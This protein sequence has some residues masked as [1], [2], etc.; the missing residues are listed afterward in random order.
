MPE[1]P[2]VET[3][4][5]GIAPHLIGQ[6]IIKPVVRH[7]RLRWPVPPELINI[8][9]GRVVTSVTRRSKYLLIDT[10]RGTLILH[11]GMSGSLRVLPSHTSPGKHDHF[12]L[13]LESGQCLRL[14]DP[15]RFGAVLWTTDPLETHPLLNRL[16]P[17]PL[18]AE[19]SGDYLHAAS[20]SRKVAV[21]TLLMDSHVVVGVGNIYANEALH[22]AHIHPLR[23]AHRIGKSH[24]D[25]LAK[26]VV[27][28]LEQAITAG[29]TT[30][31]DFSGVDGR[32]GYFKQQLR[33][34]GRAGQ[35][36]H[37]CSAP[38]SLLRLSGRATYFCPGCQRQ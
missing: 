27:T 29:G 15:R 28:V 25:Q 32:P 22:L 2:E 20:R 8:L 16:G 13:A 18:G 19:F 11:L 30:L 7:P 6:R 12:D 36:C 26:A 4:C 21:K 35:P 3:T 24:Y 38:I 33:V 34:Y 23:L 37:D 17:E 10:D 5:R 14:T 9:P 31:R 1:L